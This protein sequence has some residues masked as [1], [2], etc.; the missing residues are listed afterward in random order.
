M[1]LLKVIAEYDMERE[2]YITD[3]ENEIFDLKKKY[4]EAIGLA[5]SGAQ[6]LDRERLRAILAGAYDKKSSE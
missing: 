2:A 6:A 4:N 5:V 1:S 3:L